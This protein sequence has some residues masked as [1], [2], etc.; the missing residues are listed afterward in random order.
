MAG[1]LSTLMAAD[2]AERVVRKLAALQTVIDS[3]LTDGDKL[4]LMELI[5]TYLPTAELLDR[6]G[7]I[8]QRIEDIELTVFERMRLESQ[9]KGFEE[10]REEGHEEGREEGREEG[11]VLGKRVLLLRLLTHRFGELP[12]DLTA[13]I[14]KIWEDEV[15]DSLVEQALTANSIDELTLPESSADEDENAGSA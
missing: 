7:A 10:G 8:M 5:S 6:G 9:Q 13:R 11:Q 1:A 2:A 4:F 14:A 3:D 12:V 15:F